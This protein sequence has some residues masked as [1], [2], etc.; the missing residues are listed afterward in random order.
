MTDE[1][2]E[3]QT[4]AGAR[5][6]RR[7]FTVEQ[8]IALLDEAD[9]PGQSIAIVARKHGVSPS[10]MFRWRQLREQGALTGLKANEDLVPVSR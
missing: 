2:K 3:N 6:V 7:Q 5:K 1:K 9:Q 8:R 10:V 4:H